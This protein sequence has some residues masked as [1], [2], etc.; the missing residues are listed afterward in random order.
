MVA[1]SDFQGL[2][3][4]AK[5]SPKGG[6]ADAVRVLYDG[7]VQATQG[8]RSARTERRPER[9]PPATSHGPVNEPTAGGVAAGAFSFNTFIVFSLSHV[10]LCLLNRLP[11]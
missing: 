4:T 9:L 5:S 8:Q 3:R 2:S 10:L 11:R 1:F 7:P 6:G